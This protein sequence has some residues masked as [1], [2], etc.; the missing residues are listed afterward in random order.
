MCGINGIISFKKELKVNL[1]SEISIMNNLI[2]HRG[3]DDDGVF[4]YNDSDYSIAMG[5]RRLSIIDLSDGK[6]PIYSDN[7][8]IVIVFNGEIYNYKILR[9]ELIND[10]V[11]FKT[12]SDTEVI[13]KLYET[14]GTSSFKK[15]DGMFAFSIY[16]QTKNKVFIA[17]D[18]FGEKPLYYTKK[19]GR[20]IWASELKSV[21]KI[22]TVIPEIDKKGLNLFFKLT[23]IPAPYTIYQDIYKLE[24]NHFI[25]YDLK[26]H[27]YK[28]EVIEKT[29]QY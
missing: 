1:K 25:T 15:L 20:F 23:Y 3:P 5:M 13:L 11:I 21:L 7:K 18:F 24:P 19:E 10:G 8:K 6:Q 16:D 26:T 29:K 2:V 17:R 28:S 12:Q 14:E 22:S 27:E 4:N 9:K